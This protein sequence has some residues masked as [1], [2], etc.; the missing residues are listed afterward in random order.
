[1]E[2]AVE[3]EG[4]EEDMDEEEVDG[5]EEVGEEQSLFFSSARRDPVVRLLLPVAEK[6][7]ACKILIILSHNTQS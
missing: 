2:G 1:M 6:K 4:G 3:E 7:A 5:E